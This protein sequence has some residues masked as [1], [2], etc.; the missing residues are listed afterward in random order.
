ML[1]LIIL[2]K[3]FTY[4]L[5]FSSF[6]HVSFSQTGLMINEISQGQSG[7]KEYIE[8]VAFGSTSCAANANTIDLRGFIID[9]NNG[10]FATGG[11][12]GI[13]SGAVRFSSSNSLWQ[14]VPTGTIIVVYN[15]GDSN[16]LVPAND[17]SLTDGNC[18]LIIPI[19][20]NLLE[21]QT[22]TPT[23]AST[24][25]ISAA[26]VAGGGTWSPLGM[27][28][29]DDSFQIRSNDLDTD[30]NH[31]ISWGNN[32]TNNI[33]YFPS[34]G[35]KV[36]SFTND[37]SN[38]FTT[39]VNWSEGIVG[40]NETP[41]LA[42]NLAN[43]NWILRMNPACSGGPL[44]LNG[45]VSYS[46]CATSCDGS[47]SA[48]VQ[49]G[50]TPYTYSWSNG[51]NT[52]SV[53]NLCIGNYTFTVTDAFDCE[54]SFIANIIPGFSTQ[55]A[56]LD[57]VP[58]TL[59]TNYADFQLT[60]SPNGGSFYSSCGSCVSASGVFSPSI[61]GIGTHSVCYIAG[62]GQCSDTSCREISIVTETP[63]DLEVPNVLTPNNDNQNDVWSFSAGGAESIFCTIVNR[64]GN[65]VFENEPHSLIEWNAK[66]LNGND[67]TDGVYFYHLQLIYDW[68]DGIEK[69]GFIQVIR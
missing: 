18:R 44:N 51:A 52:A 67:V 29:G 17:L 24:S 47:A 57:S 55:I 54:L 59:E 36:F 11:G 45:I 69:K 5:V 63:F 7:V 12:T 15:D 21:W 6:T 68:K 37:F 27:A 20:S 43:D 46:N 14:A 33:I 2:R 58:L 31:S 60:Y 34:A 3:V 66:D 35:G 62:N 8:F 13:A 4:L 49:G 50:N 19:S 26:W 25:Y 53:S 23:T 22:E 65:K 10:Y 1:I 9:D 41:G 48:F 40:V 32:T 61:A 38:D 28:N 30:P 56:N 64:W 16:P 42:N 39:Q